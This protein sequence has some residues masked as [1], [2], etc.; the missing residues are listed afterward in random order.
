MEKMDHPVNDLDQ[1]DLSFKVF[2]DLMSRRVSEILLVSSPYDAF[3]ME[4]DGRLAERIIH[5]Y[6]GLNLTRPPRL[7]WVS[8]AQEALDML[9]RSKFD[10]VLTMPRIG[11]MDPQN[12][13]KEIKK[14]FPTI[15]VF[16]LTHDAGTLISNPK[17]GDP[18]P[19][20]K[21]YIWTGNTDLLLALIKNVEDRMNVVHDTQRARVRVILMVEDSPVYYSSL[22]PFLYKEVVMQTQA[23]MEESLNEEHRILRMRA[24]PKILHA[25]T[26]EDAENIYR[27]F[28]PFLLCVISD[29]RFPRNLE[30][31]PEAGS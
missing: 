25:E 1:F 27:A 22:L 13:G 29:V 5:E 23:V 21:T 26:Y 31:D 12:L 4:E 20:D 11:D 3:I 19:I 28:K 8:S 24:R 18:S 30:A 6:R 7:T 17:P 16:L 14:R 2:Y 9:I 15:P 10:L